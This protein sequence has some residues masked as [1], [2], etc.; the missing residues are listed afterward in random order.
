M[1]FDPLLKTVEDKIPILQVFLRRVRFGRCAADKHQ[2]KSRTAE[3]YIRSVAQTYL[4]LGAKDP[5]IN[6][7]E[8]DIDFRIRRM[9]NAYNK[10]D[11]PPNRV[12]PIP[13]QVIRRILL[14][15][16]NNPTDKALV[17]E[18]DM[19]AL[20][21]FFLLRLSVQQ[22]NIRPQHLNPLRLSLKMS[23]CG[24]EGFALIF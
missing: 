14:L 1:G 18:A 4:S 3:E 21:F 16:K 5:R 7:G 8:S 12:K 19:I 6:D 24:R 23:N 22:E 13:V 10:K 15:A 17:M 2:V 11:P 20:A 9:L